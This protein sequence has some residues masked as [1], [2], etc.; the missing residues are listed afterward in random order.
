MSENELPIGDKNNVTIPN[1]NALAVFEA[2]VMTAVWALARPVAV[3]EIQQRMIEDEAKVAARAG[4][5]RPKRIAYTSVLTTVVNL[6]EKGML[7]QDRNPISP[8][9]R[10]AFMYTPAMSKFEY[11]DKMVAAMATHAVTLAPK[12]AREI[13]C[14]DN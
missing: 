6:V 8:T 12:V 4:D 9:T 10:N 1:V 11:I 14:R 3:S 7:R 5:E 2:Q 13:V